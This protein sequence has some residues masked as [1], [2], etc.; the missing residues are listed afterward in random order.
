MSIHDAGSH[1]IVVGM[2]PD[3]AVGVMRPSSE[4]AFVIR[5]SGAEV[6][7]LWRIESLPVEVDHD[8]RTAGDLPSSPPPG[9]LSVRRFTVPAF[10]GVG[11]PVQMNSTDSTYLFTVVRGETELV[12]ETEVLSIHAGDFVVLPGYSHGW[13]NRSAEEC[14]IITTVVNSRA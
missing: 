9:G 14:V 7:E 1:T 4:G 6:R 8:G 13:R 3:G 12:L 2:R 10:T 5:P 11:A